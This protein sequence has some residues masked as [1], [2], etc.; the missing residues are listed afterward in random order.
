MKQR[1]ELAR[2]PAAIAERLRTAGSRWLLYG[3]MGSGKS[4]LAAGIAVALAA[5]G[6]T[7]FCVGADPGSPA[8][9]VPG[10][11][12]LGI[13]DDGGWRVVDQVPLCTLDAVRFRLPLIRA[14][15]RL[16]ATVAAGAGCLLVDA[17][18]VVRGV[19]GAE[20]LHGLAEVAAVDAVL[21]LAAPDEAPPLA[22]ELQALPCATFRIA[23]VGAAGRPSRGER[24]RARS[25]RWDAHLAQSVVCE[26]PLKGL[27]LVGTPP[28]RAAAEAWRGRQ[29]ALISDRA[30]AVMGEVVALRAGVLVAKLPQAAGTARVLLLRDAQ[31]DSRGCLVTAARPGAAP[32]QR[33]AGTDRSRRVDQN[34]LP[35]F[36]A[37]SISGVLVNGVQG[38]ALLMLRLA[39]LRQRILFDLGDAARLSPR[40]LHAVTDVFVS[41]A[42][43]DHIIGFVALLRARLN[44]DA[45]PC[46]V[47][48]P[49][50]IRE[51]LWGFLQGFRWDRIGAEAPVFLVAEVIAG[52]LRW[53]RLQPGRELERLEAQ[54]LQQGLLRVEGDYRVRCVE[55]DHGI[56]VLAFALER[57]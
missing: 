40:D 31:R 8:F 33:P 10:A 14:V 45:G 27:A 28:P 23:P 48:G 5:R 36:V 13:W 50:G 9:G 49:P 38:D 46:R 32:A 16:A 56:P 42:H 21:M 53:A 6:N 22:D 44:G 18:G 11:V 19:A 24:E 20:L 55:L 26:I 7:V 17:P 47:Y 30:S 52:E 54:T 2:D 41:H 34:G 15:Q 3:A 4:T 1:I 43:V 29:I 39:E 12:S 25:S 51:H 37:G 35:G 57:A